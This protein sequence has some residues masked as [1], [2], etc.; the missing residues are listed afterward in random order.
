M[1]LSYP[2]AQKWHAFLRQRPR[3]PFVHEGEVFVTTR[4]GTQVL[5]ERTG[6]T[7]RTEKAFACAAGDEVLW[8]ASG[9]HRYGAQPLTGRAIEGEAGADYLVQGKYVITLGIGV[10]C[11]DLEAGREL[12]HRENKHDSTWSALPGL[13]ASRVVYGEQDGAVTCVA[14]EGGSEVWRHSVSDLPWFSNVETKGFP[15]GTIAIYNDVA[16]VQVRGRWVVGLDLRTGKRRWIHQ[17]KGFVDAHQIDGQ[18]FVIG[19]PYVVLDPLNGVVLDKAELERPA[20]IPGKQGGINGPA[21]VSDTHVYCAT[22]FGEIIAWERQTG[23][24]AGVIK[25]Q[26]ACGSANVARHMLIKNGR[27][28]Y[29]D[30]SLSIFCF[31]EVTPTDPVLEQQRADAK[32]QGLGGGVVDMGVLNLSGRP[33]DLGLDPIQ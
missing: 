26:G 33:V 15:T 12:W 4:Y 22:H 30:A 23:K 5:S 31:E 9:Q 20:E 7:L 11:L 1:R 3:I 25:G 28:Y 18:Y 21:A 13:S 16:I 14:L 2:I 6:E 17:S 29:A 27:L 19:S 24:L 32:G 10:A 8:F